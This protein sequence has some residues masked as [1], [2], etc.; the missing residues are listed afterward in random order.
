[1]FELK[2]EE[3]EFRG[4]KVSVREPTVEDIIASGDDPE[5]MMPFL[6]QKC[7]YVEDQPVQSLNQLPA[8]LYEQLVIRLTRLADLGNDQ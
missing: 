8:K 3:F 1:M 2:S 6:I 4:K 5:K 7:V